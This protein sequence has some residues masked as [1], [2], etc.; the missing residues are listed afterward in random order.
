MR[1]LRLKPL[2]DSQNLFRRDDLSRNGV[3]LGYTQTGGDERRKSRRL[4][5]L[6]PTVAA[7]LAT[8]ETLR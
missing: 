4:R 6:N 3:A 7:H 1:D 2:A 5:R 8:V